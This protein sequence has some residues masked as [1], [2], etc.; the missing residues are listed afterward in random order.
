MRE[1]RPS[2]SATGESWGARVRA[3]CLDGIEMVGFDSPRMPQRSPGLSLSS[4]TVPAVST[5]LKPQPIA[6]LDTETTSLRE[7]WMPAGRRMWE[8]AVIRRDPGGS[9]RAFWSLISDVDLRDADAFALSIGKFDERWTDQEGVRGGTSEVPMM[10][11]PE[12]MVVQRLIDLTAGCHIVGSNPAFDMLNITHAA[13]RLGLRQPSW[14]YHPVDVSE[15]GVGFLAEQLDLSKIRWK[16]DVLAA[17]AGLKDPGAAR[18]TAYGDVRWT[19]D[20]WDLMLPG[21]FPMK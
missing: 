11:L 19:M 1:R 16:S 10:C 7:P 20:W 15:V 8:V 18:H 21:V 12:Q 5:D 2:S 6:W 13:Y 3:F 14:H 4:C 17:S 9:E